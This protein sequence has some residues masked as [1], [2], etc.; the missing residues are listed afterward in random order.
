MFR[1]VDDADFGLARYNTDGSLD[2]TFGDGGLVVTNIDS[3]DQTQDIVVQPDGKI[4]VVGA[5][6]DGPTQIGMA[7]YSADGSLD[8]SFGVDGIAISDAAVDPLPENILLQP[9]GKFMVV[10]NDFPNGFIDG[11]LFVARYESDGTLDASFGN[12]GIVTKS[13]STFDRVS[14]ALLQPDGKVLIAGFTREGP[15]EGNNAV[16][17]LR[18]LPDGSADTGF[19]VGGKATLDFGAS[20]VI[21]AMTLQEDGKIVVGGINIETGYALV[22]VNQDGTVDSAFATDGMLTVPGR[23]SLNDIAFQEDGRLLAVGFAEN[24]I[25]SPDFGD[26]ITMRFDLGDVSVANEDPMAF[27]KSA[28]LAS[29]F[30]NPFRQRTTLRFSLDV[31]AHAT[32]SVYDLMGREV[33]RVL[34]APRAAGQ[35]EVSFA[36]N[37][38][39]AGVYIYQLRIDGVPVASRRM[40]LMR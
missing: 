39:S 29:N 2:P 23:G 36:A 3:H 4:I 10:G 12:A 13:S 34:D 16:M 18:Y 21:E 38:L 32:L 9:D 14:D 6:G 17:V 11:E 22:R 26:I 8:A 25:S 27:P 37:E 40:V 20:I 15:S 33:A 30:P 1:R 24:D 5:V 31:P 35:S 7:R 28:T 19:G